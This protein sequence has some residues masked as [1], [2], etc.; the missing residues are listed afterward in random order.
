M[1]VF[2]IT[3]SLTSENSESKWQNNGVNIN[4]NKHL[5][6][7]RTNLPELDTLSLSGTNTLSFF[8]DNKYLYGKFICSSNNINIQNND[9]IFRNINYYLNFDYSDK[10]IFINPINN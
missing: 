2:N 3:T 4:K 9:P 6:L 8:S 1:S 5:T 7:P 10:I